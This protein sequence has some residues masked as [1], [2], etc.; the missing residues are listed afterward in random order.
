[1]ERSEV[2]RYPCVGG[3]DK[4][5]RLSRADLPTNLSLFILPA[6]VHL[7]LPTV[8]RSP[9]ASSTGKFKTQRVGKRSP[10]PPFRIT[11]HFGNLTTRG[12]QRT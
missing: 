1:M 5:P 3:S 6:F 8:E 10:Q 12:Q 2:A 11:M 9:V 4:Q 7:R